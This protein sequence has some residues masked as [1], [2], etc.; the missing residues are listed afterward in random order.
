MDFSGIMNFEKICRTTQAM[1]TQ[2]QWRVCSSGGLWE[3]SGWAIT[4]E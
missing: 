3:G 2:E 1:G 4:M